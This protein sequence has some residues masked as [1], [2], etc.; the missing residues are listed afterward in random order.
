M[1]RQKG[2]GFLNKKMEFRAFIFRT[3]NPTDKKYLF[4]SRKKYAV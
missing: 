4:K 3:C 1:S 2:L